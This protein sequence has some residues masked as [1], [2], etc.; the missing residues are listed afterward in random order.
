MARDKRHAVGFA[1]AAAACA[2]IACAALIAAPAI[3]STKS[4]R[5]LSEAAHGAPGLEVDWRAVD[6]LAPD[7]VAWL[8]VPGLGIDLPV[9]MAPDGAPSDY[10]LHRALDGSWSPYGTPYLDRRSDPDEGAALVFGH[11]A[12]MAGVMF[13]ALTGARDADALDAVGNATWSTRA[14]GELA[15]DP[16]LCMEV[17]M[18]YAGIQ[19]FPRA[20]DGGMGSWIESLA[21]QSLAAAPGWEDAAKGA[22]RVLT[23]VTCSSP[24]PGCRERTVVVF[25]A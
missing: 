23:L 1:L 17:D 10:Y 5:A 8:S 13:S 18:G 14:G 15:L 20:E 11:N 24:W 9:A 25:A 22:T 12:G 2:L 6:E 4:S 19:S 3:K 21:A 16:I 7:V